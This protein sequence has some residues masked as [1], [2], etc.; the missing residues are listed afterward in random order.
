MIDSQVHIGGNIRVEA[1]DRSGRVVA[2]A[3]TKNLVTDVGLQSIADMIGGVG[4]FPDNI[5]VGTDGSAT[6]AGMLA[7]QNEVEKLVVERRDPRVAGVDIQAL[8]DFDEANGHDLVEVAAFEGDNMI[9]RGVL[10]TP[11][12]KSNSIQVTL[13]YVFQVARP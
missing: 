11:I 5:R 9:G 7:L 12:S 13:S 3:E 6:T 1:R 2:R 4:R 8:L 10:T